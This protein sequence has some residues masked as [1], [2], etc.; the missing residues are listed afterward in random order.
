[1]DKWIYEIGASGFDEEMCVLYETIFHNANGYIGVRSNF[2]EGYPAGKT[3]IRGSYINGFYDLIPMPQ[4]EK[5]Y[6]F[7]E[8]KQTM[9]N[10]ADTQTIRLNIGSEEFSLFEGTILKFRRR[11]DMK[12]GITERIIH[13]RSP[14]G[15]ELELTI[16]RMASFDKLPLFTIDYQIKSINYQGSAEIL[17][18]HEGKVS[19]YSNPDD[20]RVAGESLS[21]L[22]PITVMEEQGTSFIVSTST[23]SNLTAC[24]A[25]CHTLSV[26]AQE[27]H[28]TT[29]HQ[30]ETRFCFSLNKGEPVRFIKY[31]IFTDSIRNAD[32][33]VAAAKEMTEAVEM[34]LDFWYKKQQEYL[35]NFWKRSDL[36]IDADAE[37]AIAVRYNLYQLL[38]SAG[39]DEFCNIAAKGLSGEGY[40]GHY[41]WDT[42]M[43]MLPFFTLTNPEIA[44]KLL[45]FRYRTLENARENARIVGHRKG[46]LYP[47]RTIMG[48]EC[49]GYFPSGT[50]AYHINGAIAY[51]VVMYY[52]LTE[53]M[54]FLS[55]MGAEILFETA[56]LWMDTGNY[57]QGR[58]ELH[59][60]TGPDEYTCLVDNNYYTNA[61]AKYNLYW[62]VR[63]WELLKTAGKLDAAEKIGL[64]EE[65]VMAFWDAQEAMYLPYDKDLGINP[66][67]DTF[68]SKKVWDLAATPKENFPL[69]LHYHPLSLY[70]HQ[71]C[72]QADTLLAHMLFEDMQTKETIE[73]SFDYYEKIT[74]HDS[75]L[76]TCIFSIIAARLCRRE[77]AYRYFGDSAKL[78]LFN[79][80]HNT[81]DG[82]HTANMGGVY[83]AVVYG[84]GGLRVKEQGVFLE[85]YLPRE[86]KAYRFVF[87]LCSRL[88]SVEVKSN[89]CRLTL[90]E[91]QPQKITVYGR[92]IYLS[93]SEVI[94]PPYEAVI[95]DLDGVLCHTDAYHYQAWKTLADHLGIPFNEEIN[96]QLR[97]VSREESLEIILSQCRERTFTDKEKQQACEEKN[98]VYQELL[99]K[100]SPKDLSAEVKNTLDHLRK[101]GL[102]L[103]VGSSSKNTQQ[104][105]ERIGLGE[106]FDAVADGTKITHAKPD[107]EVFLLAAEYLGIT[108]R[109]CLV[110]E[111]AKAGIEAAWRAGMDSAGISEAA[112]SPKVSYPLETFSQLISIC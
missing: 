23:S 101:K 48:K 103:A 8:E 81:G 13:W 104:I 62:A 44:R 105:L 93:G 70:R 108:P 6:G 67:D 50:A 18:L 65:E 58:F 71:V 107:P 28:K 10:I 109:K 24:S 96:H 111:D 91:G 52:L 27:Y 5:L 49:S 106:Y 73:K 74:T 12:K 86:W 34:S 66:Q 102:K 82:I 99:E 80:H 36:E 100:M 46:A 20:P 41:F 39:R 15:K 21:Y 57:H 11:L 25:V 33:Q 51:A 37:T 84:F 64:T 3:T 112:V 31:T 43:Y 98:K 4:A 40:E 35:D 95:F 78:D 89:E 30:A 83:L 38:Q 87:A 16:R 75:S 77:T 1:M 85:P 26:P 9:V 7:V 88:I 63:A 97:G 92:E 45:S 94:N 76:S 22:T 2:E 19:N 42:E 59:E 55:R 72:K 90:L 17:S 61:C 56:R 54:D 69:L 14:S 79:T 60:V 32:V 53:D 110:V 47:W 68:L 29:A